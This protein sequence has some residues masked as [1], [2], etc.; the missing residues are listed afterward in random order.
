VA[1][2][3]DTHVWLW[4]ARAT[5]M[6]TERQ[7]AALDAARQGQDVFVSVISVWEVAWLAEK[8]R[9]TL[10]V[11]YDQWVA[12]A[13][14]ALGTEAVPLTAGIAMESVRLPGNVHG[15]PMDRFIVATARSLG[16]RLVT[17]DRRLLAYG[18]AGHVDVLEA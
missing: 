12:T 7:V 13:T 1:L 16:A 6:M 5:P 15:D 11:P 4:Y 9:I 18:R 17:R 10:H 8:G 2:L 3:L 14:A